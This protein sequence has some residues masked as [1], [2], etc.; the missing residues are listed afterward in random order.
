MATLEVERN[1]YDPG[2]KRL[3]VYLGASP[4]NNQCENLKG[5]K[6]QGAVKGR[7]ADLVGRKEGDLVV[8]LARVTSETIQ[9]YMGA[10]SG[11]RVGEETSMVVLRT[12]DRASFKIVP[13]ARNSQIPA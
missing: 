9:D 10:L 6:L 4:V 1:S 12:H 3:R 13:G 2:R 11:L 5:V 8:E 7:P